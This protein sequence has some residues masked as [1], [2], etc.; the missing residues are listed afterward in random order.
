MSRSSPDETKAAIE[1][2]G[3][4]E[5]IVVGE[6]TVITDKVAGELP[7]VTRLAGDDRYGTNVKVANHFGGESK[8]VY[9]GTGKTY[10]DVLT[11]AVLAAK[12]NSAVILVHDRV[13]E[14][15]KTYV[16]DRDVKR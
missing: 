16:T 14:V 5:T 10:A 3:V 1:T 8:H 11:G 9:V 15:V 7:K 6:K 4:A 12:K 13:P 2:L